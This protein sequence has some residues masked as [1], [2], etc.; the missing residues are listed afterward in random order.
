MKWKPLAFGGLR[1]VG[2]SDRPGFVD[3]VHIPKAGPDDVD[4]SQWKGWSAKKGG[5]S[6]VIGFDGMHPGLGF[7]ATTRALGGRKARLPP[8]TIITG[9]PTFEIAAAAC[10]EYAK[11][12]MT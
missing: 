7:T 6:Y 1:K 12:K 9:A 10:I 3:L 11:R 4:L 2:P 8:T 5:N